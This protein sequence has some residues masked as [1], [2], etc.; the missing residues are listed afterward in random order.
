MWRRIPILTAALLGS[1]A[2]RG[3]FFL[4]PAPEWA[5]EAD[6]EVRRTRNAFFERASALVAGLDDPAKDDATVALALANA[7]G[8]EYHAYAEARSILVGPTDRQRASNLQALERP[9]E[10]IRATLPIVQAH[11][12]GKPLRRKDYPG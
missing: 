7:C 4:A 11:R 8:L 9:K 5:V 6:A 3:L 12:T 10:K 1:V 2:C